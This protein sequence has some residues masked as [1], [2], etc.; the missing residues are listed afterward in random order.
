MPVNRKE[1]TMACP[2]C[3]CKVTYQYEN[4]QYM[5]RCANCGKIFDA[6]LEGLD[7]EDDFDPRTTE[8]IFDGVER[9]I[10]EIVK[11]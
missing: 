11:A 9:T 10:T 2:N 8:E 6:E 1:S 7:E 3:E 5:E 4:S